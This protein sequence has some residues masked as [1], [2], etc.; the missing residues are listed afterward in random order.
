MNI[1]SC[2]AEIKQ[3]K[4]GIIE[5]FL[6]SNEPQNY[7]D[8]LNIMLALS[9][10]EGVSNDTIQSINAIKDLFTR[11]QFN[12]FILQKCEFRNSIIVLAKELGVDSNSNVE[13]IILLNAIREKLR[14]MDVI[15]D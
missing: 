14:T 9:D 5:D 6:S 3:A 1:E 7:L 8:A 15:R 4:A 11:L 2:I 10:F 12:D 13:P